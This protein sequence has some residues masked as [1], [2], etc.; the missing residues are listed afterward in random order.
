MSDP[1]DL[2]RSTLNAIEPSASFARDTRARADRERAGSARRRR[3]LFAAPV[4]A[5]VVVTA[6][7]ASRSRFHPPDAMPSPTT[8]PAVL[9]EAA[10]TPAS[11][12][13]ATATRPAPLVAPVVKARPVVAAPMEWRVPE[14]AHADQAIAVH[15]LMSLIQA[16]QLPLVA[17]PDQPSRERAGVELA[18]IIVRPIEITPLPAM[19]QGGGQGEDK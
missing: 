16:G 3:M 5:A 9:V 7:L 18:P 10:S 19:V 1:L 4:L 13:I 8:T 14:D 11:D 17:K 15:R 2:L 12:T 6:A